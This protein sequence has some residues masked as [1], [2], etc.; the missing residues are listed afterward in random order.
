MNKRGAKNFVVGSDGIRYWLNRLAPFA[1]GQRSLWVRG[2]GRQLFH[3]DDG[4]AVEHP[5]GHKEWYR[6]GEF[7]FSSATGQI[8]ERLFPDEDEWSRLRDY[9]KEQ[10]SWQSESFARWRLWA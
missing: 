4:P 6:N 1:E 10:N 8:G 2:R 9:V 3:R 7:L 5:S